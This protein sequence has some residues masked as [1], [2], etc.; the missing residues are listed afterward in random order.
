MPD[1]FEP[2]QPAAAVARSAPAARRGP[3]R[4]WTTEW[5]QHREI[6]AGMPRTALGRAWKIVGSLPARLLLAL[7]WIYQNTVSPALP[8]IF[9]PACGCRFAPSCSH[10]AADALRGHGLWVGLFLA[11]RRLLKCTPFHPGGYDPVPPRT[12]LSCITVAKGPST[13]G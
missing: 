10:Y 1:P 2:F 13:R 8:A 12:R 4:S 3:A 9:G 5:P 7:I 6:A 11:A